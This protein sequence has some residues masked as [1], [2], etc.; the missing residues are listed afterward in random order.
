[1]N[2]KQLDI[3]DLLEK[4]PLTRLTKNYQS[5]FI[6]K[7]K[8]SF[9]D[10]QQHIFIGSFYC[11]LNYNSKTDFVI[12][13]DSI[14]KWLG[15][16]RKDPAKVVL[17]KHFILDIDYKIITNELH[18]KEVA[19][20]GISNNLG[21]AS[22]NL[23]E[24]TIFQRP[25]GN[26]ITDETRG[27]KKEKILMTINTFKKL[28]LK[29]DT[30]KSD[31][32]H[33]YFI[34][35][36]DI[37]QEIISEE[38]NELKTQLEL[39]DNQLELKDENIIKLQKDKTLE[40]H[41]ILL[42]EFG[43]IGS[44]IYI[45]KIKTFDNGCYIIKIGES[46]R[47]IRERFL[48][49]KSKYDEALILDCFIVNKSKN[50]EKFLHNH[51]DIKFNKVIDLKKHEKEQE[52]FK[53]GY[54][55]SYNTLL[56]II[57]Q[58]IK[59]YNDYNTENDVELSKLELKKLKFI[60]NS[61]NNNK[62]DDIVEKLSNSNNI[63]LNKIDNLEKIIIELKN[64]VISSNIKTTNN[65]NEPLNTLGPRLQKINPETLQLIKVY[66]SV[67]ECLKEN[68]NIKR[69]SINKAVVENTI[70][71]GFRWMLIDRELNANIIKDLKPT[72]ITKD[73]NIGY[74]AKLNQDKS[75]ILNVYLN[76]KIAS[77][78]NNYPS[79]ASLDNVVK[80]KNLSNNNYYILYNDCS[81]E[82][83][84]KF[85]IPILYKNGVGKFN[86]KNEL[87][88]EFTCKR[89]CVERDYISDKTLNKALNNNILY[90][91][92]YYKLLFNKLTE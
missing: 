11:Y 74:I 66:E 59:Y 61:L 70:Y 49:H 63:L 58:N 26:K 76:R 7:I 25:M 81:E 56:D 28:C 10:T 43:T 77:K 67:S 21:G 36:E 71:Q 22:Q 75:K 51:K 35:L 9:T 79:Y 1:M 68:Q 5:K 20:A 17:L 89:D 55:L 19:G 86:T 62:I 69:S 3:V 12:D 64:T 54:D 4:N 8:N 52:L 15:F 87:I 80:N 24:E 40:K 45:I 85:I 38:S 92:H 82:L 31:E 90:N 2:I 84:E 78:I 23:T 18:E 50:F 46:R 6:D 41:N 44:I 27:R 29:S 65:F 57:K 83:K 39:K 73:Q 88:K 30:K 53:I 14:W 42:R 34:K 32:I 48:E 60:S 16:S 13:F 47:G 33:D 91:N 72:K 37:F